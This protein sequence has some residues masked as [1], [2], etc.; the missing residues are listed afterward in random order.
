MALFDA[1]FAAKTLAEWKAAFDAAGVWYQP[2]LRAQEVVFD[3]Q[4]T[5][6]MVVHR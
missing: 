5:D 3:P 4:V 2:I 1:A 6:D